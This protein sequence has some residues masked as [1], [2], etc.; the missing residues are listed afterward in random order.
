MPAIL[1]ANRGYTL[2]TNV[3]S[4][5]TI[6]ENPNFVNNFGPSIYHVAN[7]SIQYQPYQV[8]HSIYYQPQ[9][10][11]QSHHAFNQPTHAMNA[12]P[13]PNVDNPNLQLPHLRHNN[14]IPRNEIQPNHAV[15]Q[16]R[17]AMNAIPHQIFATQIF[18]GH[19]YEIIILYSYKEIQPNHAFTQPKLATYAIPPQIP[20]NE[21]QY[22]PAFSQPRHAMND[23]IQPNVGNQNLEQPHLQNYISYHLNNQSYYEAPNVPLGF[24]INN[25]VNSNYLINATIYNSQPTNIHY[26]PET[27]TVTFNDTCTNISNYAVEPTPETH[28]VP[29]RTNIS[30]I[31]PNVN[32]MNEYLPFLEG[33]NRCIDLPDSFLNQRY[34]YAPI[35]ESSAITRSS[36]N[37]KIQPKLPQDMTDKIITNE[38]INRQ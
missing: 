19:P 15:T 32:A 1:L 11:I 5:K 2:S 7:E 6:I 30:T 17:H 21:I 20:L 38:E 14:S 29:P 35:R 22:N 24:A 10:K 25:I 18:S 36:N 9:L 4:S 31:K 34:S 16:P 26:V 12:M 8:W 37:D 28:I 23:M 27:N 33:T 13:P 3:D